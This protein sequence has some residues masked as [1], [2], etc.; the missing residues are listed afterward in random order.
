MTK[1]ELGRCLSKIKKLHLHKALP[2][3]NRLGL[4]DTG[5]SDTEFDA[6]DG[7]SGGGDGDVNSGIASA[8]VDNAERRA[9]IEKKRAEAAAAI[10][11]QKA[12]AAASGGG[13]AADRRE[14]GMDLGD[15]SHYMERWGGAL[16]LPL[17]VIEAAKYVGR[18][19]HQLS[20]TIGQP[21]TMCAGIIALVGS[22]YP[23]QSKIPAFSEIGRVCDLTTESV[24]RSRYAHLHRYRF[25]L[26][27]LPAA[28]PQVATKVLA[29]SPPAAIP[30]RSAASAAAAAGTTNALTPGLMAAAAKAAEDFDL[31]FYASWNDVL[32]LR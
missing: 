22:L 14:A 20:L 4:D 15:L 19:V 10:A 6:A 2:D 7:S 21:S 32:T 11:K 18:R 29:S 1:H 26:L 23:D 28:P 24:T 17:P 3:P 25:E 13:S 16:K 5:D 31:K 27:P 9:L 8:G 30:E 12:R